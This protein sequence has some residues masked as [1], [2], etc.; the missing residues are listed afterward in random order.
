LDTRG[1]QTVGASGFQQAYDEFRREDQLI[2]QI[3]TAPARPQP[4]PHFLVQ[5]VNENG[6]DQPGGSS[7]HQTTR[8]I[9][10]E[11]REELA[12]CQRQSQMNILS[13]RCRV[14][15]Q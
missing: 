8:E 7:A 3:L 5:Q 6:D 9:M 11:I 2:F 15:G 1:G 12:E 10:A 4:D 13:M 14:F